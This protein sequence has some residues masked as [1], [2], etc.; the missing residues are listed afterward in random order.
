MQN[1]KSTLRSTMRLATTV[2][3]LMVLPAAGNVL[4]AFLLWALS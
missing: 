2:S 3:V 4:R 1:P